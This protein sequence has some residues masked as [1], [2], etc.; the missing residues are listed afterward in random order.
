MDESGISSPLVFDLD[1]E[2]PYSFKCQVCGAC[3]HNKSIE[4]SPF[5]AAR[6]ASELGAPLE[7]FYRLYTEEDPAVLRNRPDGS[8]IFLDASGCGV[9]P[10]RPL[11]CRMFPLGLITDGRGRERYGSLPLHP[12]CLGMPG[13]D[14][15]VATYLAGQGAL[16]YLASFR[17]VPARRSS[18]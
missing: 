4:V 7:D 12:D 1:W 9:Y 11:V 15:T 14:G 3:C 8:C 2:S 16:D 17:R 13:G 6:L 5:E 18:G 10:G